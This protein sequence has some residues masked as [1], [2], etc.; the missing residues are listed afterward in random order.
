MRMMPHATHC[1][2]HEEQLSEILH[3]WFSGTQK[4]NTWLVESLQNVLSTFELFVV[5]FLLSIEVEELSEHCP[6]YKELTL[7]KKT[8]VLGLNLDNNNRPYTIDVITSRNRNLP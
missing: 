1:A 5:R 3:C 6:V 4:N 7:K 2:W 8:L